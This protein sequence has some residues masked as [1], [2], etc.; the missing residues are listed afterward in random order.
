MWGDSRWHW[1]L[2]FA[3]LITR[4][5]V[6]RL[7]Q[8]QASKRLRELQDICRLH[9][10]WTVSCF[11]KFQVLIHLHKIPTVYTN[12]RQSAVYTGFKQSA[13]N[14]NLRKSNRVLF[15]IL[16]DICAD[17]SSRSS[18]GEITWA[19]WG[20]LFFGCLT[21]FYLC[22]GTEGKTLGWRNCG[23]IQGNVLTLTW[24]RGGL[25]GLDGGHQ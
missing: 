1:G 10:F 21:A 25:K 14:T 19:L 12:F 20:S 8:L 15:C 3:C 13:S 9:Q 11:C 16:G 4:Q 7:H 6:K 17:D 22:T 18:R 5:I 24:R 23:L 2:T